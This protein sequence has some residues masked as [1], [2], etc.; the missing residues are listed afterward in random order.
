M[1]I[2]NFK[3]LRFSNSVKNPSRID[4]NFEQ[5]NDAQKTASEIGFGDVLALIWEGVPTLWAVF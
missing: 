4:A 3:G 1:K 5:E 2:A